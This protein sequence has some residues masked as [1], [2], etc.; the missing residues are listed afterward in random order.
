MVA[1]RKKSAKRIEA[2]MDFHC[3]EEPCGG[4]VKFSLAEVTS[5]DFQAVCPKCHQTYELN[6]ELTDKLKRMLS[7]VQAIGDAEDILGS[8]NVAVNVAGGSVKIPYALL[9]T[10]LN[11]MITLNLGG[12]D[13]DFHLWI[14][15]SSSSTFN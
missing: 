15:P 2:L 13:V 14:K 3:L 11:T 4:V 8:C 12:R 10:R 1:A 9:L 5:K 6:A 7:L